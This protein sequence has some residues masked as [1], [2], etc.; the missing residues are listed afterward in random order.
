MRNEQ[1]E[2]RAEPAPEQEDW[3]EFGFE[4][5]EVP[6]WI[7]LG[8]GPFDAA[9]AHADGYTPMFA[10]HYTGPLQKMAAFWTR[11][12]L[13]TPEGLRWHTAGFA[14]KEAIRWRTLGVDVDAARTRRSNYG[15][16]AD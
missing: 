9:M 10:A 6:G 3:E 13:G 2:A 8:F 4:P 5:A 15:R 11:V 7:A 1:T 16:T 12:G 14:P